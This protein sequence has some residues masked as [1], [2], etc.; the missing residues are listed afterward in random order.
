[1]GVIIAVINN[2][3]GVG[4][5]TLSVNLAAAMGTGGT[6]PVLLV[7]LDAQCDSTDNL[8]MSGSEVDATLTGLIQRATAGETPKLS[9]YIYATRERGVSILPNHQESAW[10]EADL[11]KNIPENFH[12]LRRVLRRQVKRDYDF[13]IL[14]TP[15]NMGIYVT[16]AMIM[17]DFVLVPVEGGSL[18]SVK[19]L[20]RA[21]N[22]IR[23][24]QEHANTDLRFLRLVINRVDMRT[25][26][27]RAVQDH[28]H[29]RYGEDLICKTWIPA[30]TSIQQA[31]AAGLSVLRYNSACKGS[32][33]FRDLAKEI[34][35]LTGEE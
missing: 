10:I 14:D 33:R 30:N 24:I 7:D 5:S 32:Q 15:P 28:L 1:M 8:G 22:T 13:T 3:G 2:K 29:T 12:I 6:R 11:Y 34:I 9:E 19:G 16:M 26:I 21:I 25:S 17:A 4:K 20:S 18:R 27:A 23:E 35:Q 31:E